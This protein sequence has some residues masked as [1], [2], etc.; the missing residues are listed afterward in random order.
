MKKIV[1]KGILLFYP[2][3]DALGI[4]IGGIPFRLGE[5]WTLVI[6]LNYFVGGRRKLKKSEAALVLILVINFLLT[7]LGVLFSYA[8]IDHS[9][10]TKYLFRNLIFS[11]SI[12]AFLSSNM[13]FDKDDVEKLMYYTVFLQ[14]IFFVVFYMTGYYMFMN[15]FSQKLNIYE[16]GQ[17]VRIG[18]LMIRRFKGT[19]SESGY[20]APFLSITLY[21]FINIFFDKEN[22]KRRDKKKLMG[23]ICIIIMSLFTFSSAVYVIQAVT[24]FVALKRNGVKGKIMLV[25][26]MVLGI[27]VII[28]GL[29]FVPTISNFIRTDFADKISTYLGLNSKNFSYSAVDRM[30]HIRNAWDMFIHGNLLEMLFGHGTGAYLVYSRR[31]AVMVNEV[32]EAYNL[33]L[34]T[35]TDRGLLG[36]VLLFLLFLFIRKHRIRGDKNSETI[37]W[38]IFCQCIHWLITGNLWQYF[39]FYEI[40]L[41][42]GYKRNIYNRKVLA[43]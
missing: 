20:L 41:L 43:Q 35:L 7:L 25:F 10:A 1:K 8:S 18:G 26:T 16:Q 31:S 29:L 34:S 30:Q 23:L 15:Q 19:A 32:E 13:E 21:Y 4:I 3:R 14:M 2:W 27:V 22:K 12:F 11:I 6:G 24:T 38:G 37:Y 5:L 9:F 40:M 36:L 28:A 39:F 17:I 33:Y 42:I